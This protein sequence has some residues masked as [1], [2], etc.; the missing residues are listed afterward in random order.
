V[1]DDPAPL[2]NVEISHQNSSQPSPMTSLSLNTSLE[3]S[4]APEQASSVVNTPAMPLYSTGNTQFNVDRD[5]NTLSIPAE[6][7][8]EKD[9]EKKLLQF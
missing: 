3:S 2:E 4:K 8:S 5:G 1:V 6:K 9:M 7:T